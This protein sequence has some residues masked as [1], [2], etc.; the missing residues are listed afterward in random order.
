MY[1]YE[2]D[3]R[4]QTIYFHDKIVNAYSDKVEGNGKR[5]CYKYQ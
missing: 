2:S 1:N 4:Y 5:I 3:S